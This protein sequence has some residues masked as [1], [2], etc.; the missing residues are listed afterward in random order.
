MTVLLAEPTPP[1]PDSALAA[2]LRR[3]LA[4]ASCPTYLRTAAKSWLTKHSDDET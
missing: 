3:L 4:T 2:A 1:E